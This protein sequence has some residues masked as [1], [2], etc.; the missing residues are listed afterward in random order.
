M[1][2][3]KNQ[4]PP[5]PHELKLKQ[6]QSLSEEL[7]NPAIKASSRKEVQQLTVNIVNGI[8]TGLIKK[9]KSAPLGVFVPLLWKM[10][11]DLEGTG[12]AGGNGFKIGMT[13]ETLSLEMT[14]ELMDKYLKGNEAFKVEILEQMQKEG[15]IKTEQIDHTV[16]INAEEVEPKDIK[17]DPKA[18]AQILR[19][20]DC[21]QT[22]PQA[23]KLF[24]RS[25]DDKKLKSFE[26][27]SEATGFGDLF[28][29]PDKKALPDGALHK[30]KG[31]YEPDPELRIA[32]LWFTCQQCQKKV[33]NS[34][35][36]KTELCEA[37]PDAD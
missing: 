26:R 23:R 12:T 35:Q 13:K 5:N 2:E 31:K 36:Y 28:E 20:T 37:L 21:P 10:A 34:D 1:D 29:L 19:G 16:T 15:K 18:I 3:P 30:F 6:L 4:P 11:K 9:D 17:T 25:L 32:V 7:D 8:L 14:D 24:G 22:I 33:R 27:Q